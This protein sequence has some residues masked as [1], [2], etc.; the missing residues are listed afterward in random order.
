MKKNE[1]VYKKKLPLSAF[2]AEGM[3]NF[4]NEIIS[5]PTSVGKNNTSIK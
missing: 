4:S 5:F 1:D 3:H 2:Y